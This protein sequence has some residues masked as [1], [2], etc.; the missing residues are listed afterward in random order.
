M[1]PAYRKFV[2]LPV[3]VVILLLGKVLLLPLTRRRL[4]PQLKALPAQPHVIVA[5]HKKALDPFIIAASL[6]ARTIFKLAPV[7]F[8]THN[9]FYDSIIRP[10]VWAAGCFPAKNPKAKHKLFGVEGGSAFI[11]SGYSLFIFPEGTRVRQERGP[12]RPGVIRIHQAAPDVPFVLCRIAYQ[13]GV[14]NLLTGRWRQVSYKVV[15]RPSYS[16]PE[17]LMDEIFAL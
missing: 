1:A 13:K 3:Q 14:R 15:R 9:F 11:K 2:V 8:M 7:A 6:P 16:D 10:L 4:P 17:K 12:A 5:N